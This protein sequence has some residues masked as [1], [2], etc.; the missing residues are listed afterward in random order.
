MSATTPRD[1]LL[2]LVREYQSKAS[3][4]TERAAAD[5]DRY[6]TGLAG[7]V[8]AS[9]CVF[10]ADELLET[11]DVDELLLGVFCLGACCHEIEMAFNAEKTAA[12]MVAAAQS[13]K[14]RS[15]NGGAN[16]RIK[17]AMTREEELQLIGLLFDTEKRNRHSD[18]SACKRVS[19]KL[20]VDHGIK[21][22]PTT[23]RRR[24]L[25]QKKRSNSHC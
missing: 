17:T 4:V 1:T 16:S 25:E 24:V 7:L 6:A 14:T 13:G 19:A 11:E 22:G 8:A 23:V 9:K 2:R 5:L 12:A 21:M 15:A 18:R 3:T 20:L 10:K